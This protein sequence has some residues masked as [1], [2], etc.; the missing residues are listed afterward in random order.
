MLTRKYLEQKY[1]ELISG[2]INCLYDIDFQTK[3]SELAVECIEKPLWNEER[4]RSVNYI[5]RISNIAYNNTSLDVLPLDDGVY[6][7]LLEIYKTY[8]PNYQVGAIPI[9]YDE[10]PQNE[11]EEKKLLC[12]TIT[13]EERDSKIYVKD[14]LGQYTRYDNRYKTMVNPNGKYIS[15]KMVNVP[16]K[17]PEL[18][19]TLDKCKFVLNNDAVEKGVFDTPSV[20]IFERDF[21]QKHL[22]LNY[23]NTEY[24]YELVGELKYD[25]ISVEAEVCG[26]RIVTAYSRGDT[27]EDFG[28]DLTPILGGYQ[29][30]NAKSIPTDIK[31]GIKFEAVITKHDLDLMAE[32]RGKSYKNCRNAIIGLFGSS[33]AYHYR[34]LITLIPLATS[35]PNDFKSRIHELEFLNKYYNSGQYNRFIPLRGNYYD[36]LFKV[37]QFTESAEIARSILPYLIDGVV[38]SYTDK[39][40]IDILGRKN[41]VNKYS[42]AIKFNPK[43][44]RTTFLGYTYSVGKTGDIIPMVHFKPCEFIG[45]IHDKTTA[46]SYERFKNLKLHK[47]DQVDIEYVNEVICYVTKPDTEFNRNNRAPLEKF[48]DKCPS[49]GTPIMISDSGKTA[50]CSNPHCPARMLGRMV[51]MLDRL[52]FTDFSEESIKALNLTSFKQLTELTMEDCL[53]LGPNNAAKLINQRDIIMN[54]PIWDYKVMSAMGFSNIGTEKWKLIL[55]N[56]DIKDIITIPEE[57]LK[58]S[59]VNIKSI[60][61]SI[62]DTISIERLKYKNDLD[63][64]LRMQ[65]IMS[66]KGLQDRPKIVLSGFRDPQFIELLNNNG[67]DSSDTYGLTK[68]TY[69]LIVADKAAHSGKVDKAKKFGIPI[70]TR[71]EFIESEN[72]NLQ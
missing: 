17:Y 8:D 42:I 46:H 34:D 11:F 62:A 15:K 20:Q 12:H 43:K 29:F 2:D 18:V 9:E 37:K 31:F 41:S 4:T 13:E 5:L 72:I 52:G 22:M 33:D 14:I 49:C 50:Y 6:D 23:I 38:I 66:S 36:L 25:G 56:L 35:M 24:E 53:I 47:G 16:H 30:P 26:D 45:T 40:L 60:G 44:V 7:Q 69:C 64:V 28:A 68:N 10:T 63:I 54:Q 70:K 39:S 19:G 48:I 71:Q 55:K 1:L 61:N 27:A 57:V 21:L 32:Q 51:D 59:L 58:D 67:F 3:I 65:N